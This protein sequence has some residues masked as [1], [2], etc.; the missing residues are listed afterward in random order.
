MSPSL[1][2]KL[3]KDYP[4]I[5]SE[6]ENKTSCMSR[7][8]ECGDGWYPLIDQLCKSIQHRID[9][10]DYVPKKGFRILFEKLWNKYI[11]NPI[12]YPV[13]RRLPYDE[14]QRYQ[15]FYC[16]NGATHEKPKES[17]PQLVMIQVKEKFGG[18]RIYSQGGDDHI[19]S[20][21]QIVESLSYRICEN[22]GAM[23]QTVRQTR[24]NWIRTLCAD[25]SV[26]HYQKYLES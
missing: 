9:N 16:F 23:N 8:F 13:F 7:G 1:D 10:P 21:I 5:F 19:I 2:K 22:C 15:N 17:I 6:R 18:L 25:C 4:K 14:Y 3:V 12:L 26:A 11:W 24:T 20:M